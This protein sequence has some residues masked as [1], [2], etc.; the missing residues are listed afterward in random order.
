MQEQPAELEFAT[1][2]QQILA[3]VSSLK[4]RFA[5]LIGTTIEY[6]DFYIFG[7]AAVLVF[8]KLYFSSS[9]ETMATLQSLA[10]FGLA[11]IARPVG[12]A[13]F[14][15]FGDRVG[16]KATLVASLLTMGLS[17]VLIGV[18]PSYA[19]IGIAAPVILA[20]LRFGQGLGLGGEWGG[21]I[22]LA[23]ENAPEGK[24]AWFG[25]FPQ[26][27]GPIGFFLSGSVFL[28]LTTH[29]PEADFLEWGWRIPFVSSVF[30]VL[31]GLYVRLNITETPEFEKVLKKRQKVK[32]P[33]QVVFTS[34]WR[35]LLLGM[36]SG[37]GQFV[38]FY[39]I[40]VFTL[41]WATSSL[42]YLRQDFLLL[43][44]ISVVFFALFIPVAAKLAD[45]RGRTTPLLI[46]NLGIVVLGLVM[47]ALLQ[48]GSLTTVLALS[49]G[50]VLMGMCF[51]P[52]GTLMSDLF[53]AEV[54]YTGASLGF[55][56]S[57]IVGASFAPYIATWLATHH[58]LQFVSYYLSGMAAIS[59]IALVFVKNTQ[60]GSRP[61]RA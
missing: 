53:P 45:S 19:S 37:L 36:L 31:V 30:L 52:L 32:V 55:N 3:L 2:E 35:G 18:L 24:R 59:L 50:M 6:F 5:S 28:Y 57:A 39:L 9:D 60:F 33:I 42:G 21:A 34:Y 8:P 51:G 29:L 16:R 43:Q 48:G 41:S 1:D 11:F 10:T 40:T 7:T 15:H 49:L 27:G 17:T 46:G 22:L 25:M 14:G 12:S 56:L 44:L 38:L 20:F 26:L 58:G 61:D 4:I 54:R 23:T 47:G 13:L